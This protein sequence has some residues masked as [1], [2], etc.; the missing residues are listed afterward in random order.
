V[1]TL[2]SVDIPDIQESVGTAGSLGILD[3]RAFP[4][5]QES[6]D[7]LVGPGSVVGQET[8]ELADI[9][10]LVGTL[11]IQE[12]VDIRDTRELAATRDIVGSQGILD[13][14]LVAIL[15]SLV[16]DM[17]KH[18]LTSIFPCTFLL[19]RTIWVFNIQ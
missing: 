12:S 9:Q 10:D 19:L 3:G 11:D 15:G 18:S 7:I 8:L 4:D 5:I 2:V 16:W 17:S 1:G 13:L 14:A 6:V